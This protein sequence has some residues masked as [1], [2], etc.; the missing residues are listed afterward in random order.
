MVGA[1]I[2]S[3]IIFVDFTSVFVAIREAVRLWIRRL[4]G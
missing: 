1:S 2:L 4:V 3:Q